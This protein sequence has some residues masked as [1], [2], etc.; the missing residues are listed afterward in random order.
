MKAGSA[1]RPANR[2]VLFQAEDRPG[3][4]I[5]LL[6]CAVPAVATVVLLI[7]AL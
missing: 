4:L 2:R 6:L 1:T 3:L 5:D 7:L